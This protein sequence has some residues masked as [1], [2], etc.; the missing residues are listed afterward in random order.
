MEQNTIPPH[1]Q[2]GDTREDCQDSQP[3]LPPSPGDAPPVPL[4]VMSKKKW[5][6]FFC[7]HLHSLLVV[8]HIVLIVVSIHHYEHAVTMDLNSFS[9]TWVPLIVSVVSQIIATVSLYLV[10]CYEIAI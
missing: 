2:R 4:T 1:G 3:F 5:K 6:A 10:K 9:T 7:S 8:V